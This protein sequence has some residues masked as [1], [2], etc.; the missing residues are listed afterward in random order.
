MPGW[1]REVRGSQTVIHL[2]SFSTR[3]VS[4][5]RSVERRGRLR[6]AG[7]VLINNDDVWVD[8]QPVQTGLPRGRYIIEAMGY[9]DVTKPA[10]YEPIFVDVDWRGTYELKGLGPREAIIMHTGMAELFPLG[11]GPEGMIRALLAWAAVL[12]LPV[13]VYT[14]LWALRSLD[15][16][17][18]TEYCIKEHNTPGPIPASFKTDRGVLFAGLEHVIPGT[19]PPIKV[20]AGG[21][22]NV[23]KFYTEKLPCRGKFVFA[24]ITGPDYSCFSKADWIV[25]LGDAQ[26]DVYTLRIPEGQPGC[27]VEYIGLACN[28]FL[29][30]TA[31]NIYPDGRHPQY[32]LEFMSIFN[33]AVA[34]LLKRYHRL[35]EVDLFHALDYHAGAAPIHPEAVSCKGT[36]LHHQ[37]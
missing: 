19:S 14:T 5:G 22:G 15:E 13:L 24:M 7:Y 9:R 36:P 28:M 34:F 8:A 31:A 32:F 18:E 33:R 27:D 12:L 30:R 23:C 21:L 4:F 6:R 16:R 25:D 17:L 37:L 1:R 11:V 2:E 3:S 26:L 29:A 20:S 35:G 10:C